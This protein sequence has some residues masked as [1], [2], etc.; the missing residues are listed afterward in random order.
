VQPFVDQYGLHEMKLFLTNVNLKL[1]QV[2]F[3]GTHW[4]RHWAQLQ[5]CEDNKEHIHQICQELEA[6]T[7]HF[8]PSFGLPN[9]IVRIEF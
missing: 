4:L 5:L 9:N 6:A 7:A 8:F 3:R 1:F 2:L